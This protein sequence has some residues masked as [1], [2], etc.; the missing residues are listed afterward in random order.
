[1]SADTNT[2]ALNGTDSTNKG[3]ASNHNDSVDYS[4][5]DNN[6][7]NNNN[8]YALNNIRSGSSRRSFSY[9][10]S[11][12]NSNSTNNNNNSLGK[13][14][15]NLNSEILLERISHGFYKNIVALVGAGI[16]V[17]SGIPDF[18]SYD[19]ANSTTGKGKRSAGDASPTNPYDI[20]NINFWKNDATPFNQFFSQCITSDLKP[21]IAHKFLSDLHYRGFLRGV[22]TQNFDDLER[23][24]GIPKEKLVQLH[25]TVSQ[26]RCVSE[27]CRSVF[28]ISIYSDYV[29]GA[30]KD[31]PICPQCDK[32]GSKSFIKPDVVF[33]QEEVSENKIIKA[34]EFIQG[35]D[36][37]LVV[38]T[39]LTVEPASWIAA[40]F[41]PE[42]AV[43]W[44]INKDEIP[45]DVKG[46]KV[47]DTR[48]CEEVLGKLSLSASVEL[49]PAEA[50]V[51]DSDPQPALN[52]SISDF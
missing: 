11:V 47:V 48:V 41:C 7:N 28:P 13:I 23:K 18:R 14:V 1:M 36:L 21:G 8:S 22:V 32:K 35:C 24:A 39:S 30:N 34:I 45:L 44:V 31:R 17:A 9:A 6:N 51:P 42:S 3:A 4:A 25:G 37:L 19:D 38:G 15:E 27:S 26:A 33:F 43:C 20:F 52:Q 10:S 40:I 49:T 12:F 5:N 2:T 16:S 46:K 50:Y 29:K